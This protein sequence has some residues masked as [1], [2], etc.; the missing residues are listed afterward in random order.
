MQHN[1][2]FLTTYYRLF[3]LAPLQHNFIFCLY[4]LC[5]FCL[6]VLLMAVYGCKTSGELPAYLSINSMQVLAQSNQGSAS[7]NIKNVWVFINSQPLGVYELPASVPV[8]EEGAVQVLLRAGIANNG[9]SE[10]RSIYPFY[11]ADTFSVQLAPMQA[12]NR[13]SLL[14]YNSGTAFAF[15]TDFEVGNNFDDTNPNQNLL[16]ITGNPALV[17]EG[18][19]SAT[20]TIS[21]ANPAFE[22][23]TIDYYTLPGNKVPVYLELNYQC[24]QPFQVAVKGVNAGGNGVILPVLYVNTK[25]TW[26]KIYIDLTETVSALGAEGL[27]QFQILFKS[28][29][30]NN[31]ATQASFYWD[32]IKLLYQN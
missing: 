32:N 13:N 31:G 12:I 24:D 30:E 2:H 9:I 28:Q 5:G 8:L 27:N 18:S 29:L 21:Q 10:T 26:N 7:H 14:R 1:S 17:F 25:N 23:G 3:T 22:I 15:I 6:A 20:L 11:A 4:K 16:D 19:R